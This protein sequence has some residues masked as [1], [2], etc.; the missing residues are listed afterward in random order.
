[1]SV[2][3]IENA[4]TQLSAKD[5]AELSAWLGDYRAEVWDEQLERDLDTGRL[6][7]LLEE[8]DAEFEAGKAEP[9]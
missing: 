9:L 5:L 2:K 4:I 7:A 6:D 1:M 8:V 3:D